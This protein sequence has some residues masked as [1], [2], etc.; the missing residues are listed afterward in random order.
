MEAGGKLGGLW[1]VIL[2]HENFHRSF[3]AAIT[4]V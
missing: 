4:L 3:P 1:G 2:L